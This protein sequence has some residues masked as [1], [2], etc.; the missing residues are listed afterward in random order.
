MPAISNEDSLHP[1]LG[2]ECHSSINKTKNLW[3]MAESMTGRGN[4]LDE[5]KV[6][7]LSTS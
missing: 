1:D 7:S 4:L 6:C 3:I 5:P 2:L